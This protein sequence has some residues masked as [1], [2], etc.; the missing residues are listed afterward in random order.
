[1]KDLRNLKYF[2]GIEVLRSKQGIFINQRKYILDLLAKAG[3]V[4]CNPSET[5]IMVNHGLQFLKGAK[6]VDCERYQ[7]MVGKFIYLSRTQPNP[8]L[9]MKFM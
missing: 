6:L 7:R 4:D 5:P 9:H 3:L 1:M 8:T 2:W